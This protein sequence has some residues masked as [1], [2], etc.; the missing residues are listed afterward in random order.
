MACVY[1][2]FSEAKPTEY[3]YVGIS[4]HDTAERR[5]VKHKYN[6]QE[7]SKLPVYDWMRKYTDISVKELEIDLSFEVAKE[8]EI[9]YIAKF[10]EEGHRLLN[11]TSGGDGVL[12]YVHSEE[13]R[14]K[15]SESMKKTLGGRPAH[16]RG[17]K[18]SEESRKKMS[19]AHTGRTSPNK[20]KKLSEEWK[21]NMSEAH[22]KR[23]KKIKENS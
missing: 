5:F 8:K 22:K 13:T 10:R 7:G 16:N 14:R 17:S 2:L 15:K 9:F 21:Q 3:R 1:I 6:A 18:H 20:G 4:Q 23:W 12:G 11:L 19:E